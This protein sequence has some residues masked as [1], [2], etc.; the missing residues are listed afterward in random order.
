MDWT[1]ERTVQGG[2]FCRVTLDFVL[3]STVRNMFPLGSVRHLYAIKSYHSH[4]LLVNT[5]EAQNQRIA[6]SRAFRY[7]VLLPFLCFYFFI[8]FYSITIAFI[9]KIL[10]F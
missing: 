5:L 2:E 3:L 8:L 7:E 10:V 1:F 9:F 4:V 6:K